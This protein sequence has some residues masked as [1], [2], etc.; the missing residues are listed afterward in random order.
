MNTQQLENYMLNDPFIR[1]YYGGVLAVDQLPIFVTKP[2]I[3]I[4]N[5]DPIALPGKHWVVLFIDTQLCEHFDSSGY[6]PR[7][8]FKIFLNAQGSKYLYNNNRLQDFDTE[9]CGLFCL[10]YCYFRC[11]NNNFKEILDMFYENLKLNE[12]TVKYF[13]ASTV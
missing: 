2:S 1:R 10:F 7:H 6:S 4:V 8:D 3:F 12:I 5:T 9:T 13:Y 11:R